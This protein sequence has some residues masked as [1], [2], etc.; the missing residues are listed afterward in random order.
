[1]LKELIAAWR[2]RVAARKEAYRSAAHMLNLLAH[3]SKMCSCQREI[4]RKAANVFDM[5]GNF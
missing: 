4:L 3:D 2:D 5:Q 1:M